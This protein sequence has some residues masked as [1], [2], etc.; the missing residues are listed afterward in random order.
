MRSGLEVCCDVI[1]TCLCPQISS[2][3]RLGALA[4]HT[5][6]DADAYVMAVPG[7]GKLVKASEA[8]E[9]LCVLKA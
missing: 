4:R 1:V 2:L 6:G 8:L 3:L 7:A 5:D 9:A